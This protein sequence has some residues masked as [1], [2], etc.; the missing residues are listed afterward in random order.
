MP[1]KTYFLN[2]IRRRVTSQKDATRKNVIY[3]RQISFVP[4]NNNQLRNND[5]ATM[6]AGPSLACLLGCTSGHAHKGR[7]TG[8]NINRITNE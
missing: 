5:T 3:F 6:R 7:I 2:N 4:D 8:S 1:D